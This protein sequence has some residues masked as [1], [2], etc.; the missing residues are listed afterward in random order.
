MDLAT[1][2]EIFLSATSQFSLPY[3][4]CGEL[5]E[6]G[7]VVL[8]VFIAKSSSRPRGVSLTLADAEAPILA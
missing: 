1:N 6:V 3:E 4:F 2:P 8:S 5:G 7:N